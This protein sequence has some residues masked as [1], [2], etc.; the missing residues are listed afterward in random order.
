[1]VILYIYS[2]IYYKLKI[3]FSTLDGWTAGLGAAFW[4]GSLLA[5]GQQ[6]VQRY[7]SVPLLTQSK[8]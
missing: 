8:T 1:M 6:Q 5:A 7:L 2:I 4:A 3:I